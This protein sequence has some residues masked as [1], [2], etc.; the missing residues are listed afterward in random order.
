MFRVEGSGFRPNSTEALLLHS[1]DCNNQG[2]D[3]VDGFASSFS[4]PEAK[5]LGLNEQT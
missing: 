3:F 4:S 1:G 5:S 2:P